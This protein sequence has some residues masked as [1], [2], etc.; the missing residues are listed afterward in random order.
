M[1]IYYF[2]DYHRRIEFFDIKLVLRDFM[3][4]FL[5]HTNFED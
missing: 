5:D 2:T 1:F 4:I 3:Q